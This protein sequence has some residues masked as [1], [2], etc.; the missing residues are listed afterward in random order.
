MI[1]KKFDNIEDPIYD[2]DEARSVIDVQKPL[3]KKDKKFS[4]IKNKL[5]N[6][7]SKNFSRY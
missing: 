7:K 3:I 6:K 1:D 5:K 4:I 2:I